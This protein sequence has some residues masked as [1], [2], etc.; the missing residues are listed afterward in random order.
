MH[1]NYM[2]QDQDVQY[3][4][5]C[6]RCLMH[7]DR[8]KMDAISEISPIIYYCRAVSCGVIIIHYSLVAPIL[9]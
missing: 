9:D 4:L 1:K 5:L 2:R 7:S 6:T 8:I 3:T